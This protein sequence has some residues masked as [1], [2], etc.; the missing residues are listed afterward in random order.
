MTPQLDTPGVTGE[1]PL[2]P[3]IYLAL[4]PGLWPANGREDEHVPEIDRAFQT[5][6]KI[7]ESAARVFVERG[8]VGA[9]MA[10]IIAGTGMTRGAV[11]FHFGSKA[12]L[13]KALIDR[14]HATWGP[15]QNSVAEH[16]LQG[17]DAI[18]YLID[19]IGQQMH[20]DPVAR[21]AVK[22]SREADLIGID[23]DSPFTDWTDIFGYNLRQAQLLGQMRSDLDPVTYAGVLVGMFL[24]VEDFSRS[25]ANVRLS[26][27][28][29]RILNR[30]HYSLDAMWEIALRGLSVR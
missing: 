25:P 12:E 14:Q 10:E 23:I 1:W 29:E 22:L 13:A 24:G 8:Y 15:L 16:G 11:Y 21:A 20:D 18:K 30:T 6:E 4:N 3:P 2:A 27:R 19:R 9:G 17:L 28:P 7:V 26:T 5:R